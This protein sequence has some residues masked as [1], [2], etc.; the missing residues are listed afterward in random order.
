MSS[1]SNLQIVFFDRRENEFLN[2]FCIRLIRLIL[3]LRKTK[4]QYFQKKLPFMTGKFH[5]V[6]MG[7]VYKAVGFEEVEEGRR[8]KLQEYVINTVGK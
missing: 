1:S 6:Q 5:I 3:L 4:F 2:K 7:G 8:C